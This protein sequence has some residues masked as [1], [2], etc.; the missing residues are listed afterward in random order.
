MKLFD[1]KKYGNTYKIK[2]EVSSYTVG[3]LAISMV[4]WNDGEP[5]LWNVL[6]V[7]LNSLPSKNCAYIDVN[8]NGEEILAWIKRNKLA[9]PTGRC[10]KS[11]FCRYPEYRFH[12]K[13]LQEIDPEG[14]AEYLR[15]WEEVYG[16]D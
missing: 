8:N 3:D 6:T 14:Y 5:S 2:L 16:E 9:V 1:L 10:A 11:G 15:Y 12:P 7:N 13:V 4:S